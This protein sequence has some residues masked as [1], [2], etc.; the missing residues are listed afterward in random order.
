MPSSTSFKSIAEAARLASPRMAKM[1]LGEPVWTSKE[2][3]RW[4]KNLSLSLCVSGHNRG[5]WR[6]FESG[7]HGDILDLVQKLQGLSL[8]DAAR[9]VADQTGV[10]DRT[11]IVEPSF[12]RGSSRPEKL[13]DARRIWDASS[14]LSGSLAEQYLRF[15]LCGEAIPERVLEDDSVRYCAMSHMPARR[16]FSGPCGAMIAKLVDP[17]SNEFRGVQRTFLD[18]HGRRF[19][20]RDG[21]T[22]TARLLGSSGVVKLWDDAEVSVGLALGEGVETCL[23]A[24]HLL[25]GPPVWATL[26]AS[27]LAGFPPLTGIEAVTLY[28]DAD[29]PDKNG[30][31]AGEAAAAS[32]V[33]RWNSVAPRVE[34]TRHAPRRPGQDFNDL[35]Q[36]VFRIAA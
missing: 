11:T 15:R 8:R 12:S 18:A 30:R 13:E 25:G 32:L 1:L 16:R 35:L 23:S 6:D 14:H 31:K 28:V 24:Y 2:E 21:T 33:A 3:W 34:F 5:R 27:T 10:A 29:L 36:D 26:S 22:M 20:D 17:K 4:R 9:W 19:I 7:E